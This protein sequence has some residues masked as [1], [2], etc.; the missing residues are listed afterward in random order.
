MAKINLRDHYPEYG[1]DCVAEVPDGDAEDFIAAMTKEI[2]DVYVECQR[3]ENAYLR[4]KYRRKAHYSLNC[5]DGIENDAVNLSP[6]PEEIIFDRLTRDELQTALAALPETQRRRVEAHTIHC[7]TYQAIATAE[8]V[9]ESSI[10][11]S[12]KRALRA[13]EKYLKNIV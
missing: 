5:G 7:A 12:V 3:A 11:A 9:D 6:M 2:A 8:G 13:M 10:R 4:R 1:L